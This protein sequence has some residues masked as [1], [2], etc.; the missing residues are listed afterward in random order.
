ME[1][2]GLV[3]DSAVPVTLLILGIE[4]S[5]TDYGSAALRI[6]PAVCIKLL[7]APLVAVP[8]ATLIGFENPTVA[9]VFSLL[10]IRPLTLFI[11]LL[12]TGLVV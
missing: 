1:T 6:P 3:G 9:R 2:V 7:A 11:A 8:I 10:S 12:R 4:L 5:H